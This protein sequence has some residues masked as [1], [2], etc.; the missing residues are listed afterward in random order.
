MTV[1]VYRFRGLR[2][3]DVCSG[4]YAD[5]IRSE[6]SANILYFKVISKCFSITKYIEHTPSSETSSIVRSSL[7][8]ILF[9]N[10]VKSFK[11]TLK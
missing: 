7:I 6:E 3:K 4:G 1:L 9:I 8:N 11:F 10:L 2:E 5:L